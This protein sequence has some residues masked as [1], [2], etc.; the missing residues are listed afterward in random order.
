MTQCRIYPDLPSKKKVDE[1]NE[2][3]FR[4]LGLLVSVAGAFWVWQD[5]RRLRASGASLTPP[6][7]TVLVFLFWFVS[8]P[9]YLLLR[10][11][12]WKKQIEVSGGASQLRPG[13]DDGR[14]PAEIEDPEEVCSE[15]AIRAL[16]GDL[17]HLPAAEAWQKIRHVYHE[18][19]CADL[20]DVDRFEEIVLETLEPSRANP[21]R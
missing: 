3:L 8:L 4:S 19:A 17:S 9:A 7:W 20:V 1:S 10:Q 18:N 15:A 14:A 11:W 6:V 21:G 13:A 5:S 12:S 16:A 2:L